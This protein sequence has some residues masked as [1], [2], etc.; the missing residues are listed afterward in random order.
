M[1][2]SLALM[3][4]ARA[5]G[6]AFGRGVGNWYI[7]LQSTQFHVL[8]YA[9]RTLPNMLAFVLSKHLQSLVIGHAIAK[10][11]NRNSHRCPPTIPPEAHWGYYTYYIPLPASRHLYP[12]LHSHNPPIRDCSSLGHPNCNFALAAPDFSHPRHNTRRGYRC[13]RWSRVYTFYRLLL[14]AITFRSDSA[15][16]LQY[17]NSNPEAWPALARVQCILLQRY[18]G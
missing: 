8:F 1:L 18:S 11:R 15:S 7:L 4:Y 3:S 16:N 5:A 10:G 2:N 9:S 17:P 13:N 12:D 6:R 14:L